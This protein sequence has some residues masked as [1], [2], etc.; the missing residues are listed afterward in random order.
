MRAALC[1]RRLTPGELALARSMFGEAI[2]LDRVRLHAHPFGGFAVTLGRRVLFPG[3]LPP[4]FA[5]EPLRVQAW[6]VHELVHVWQFQTAPAATLA[7]WAKVSASGGYGPG[8]PGYRY[9]WPPPPW[10]ELNLEQQASLVEHA[11][12]ARG[13][14]HRHT[15]KGAGPTRYAGL[16]PFDTL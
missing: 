10:I 5:A 2:R 1:G 15:P 6:L 3:A 7:S 4:D 16:T 13:P 8:L 14:F 12:L 9:P 11:F